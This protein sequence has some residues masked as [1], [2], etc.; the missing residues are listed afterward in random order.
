MFKRSL[1]YEDDLLKAV[2]RCQR[3]A[4][5]ALEASNLEAAAWYWNEMGNYAGRLNAYLKDGAL[6]LVNR[7]P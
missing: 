7:A 1:E 4:E 6:F 3:N 2:R 5:L